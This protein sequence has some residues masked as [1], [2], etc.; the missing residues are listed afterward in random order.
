MPG[1]LDARLGEPRPGLAG[2][3]AEPAGERA[4]AHG[5]VLGQVGELERLVEAGQRPR[6]RRAGG[7]V[8]RRRAPAA[9]CTAPARR[10][11]AAAR[12]VRRATPLATAVPWSRRTRCRHRSMPAALPAEVSTSPSSMK[13]TSASTVTSGR[14]AGSARRGPSAWWRGGRRAVRRRRARRRRCRWTRAGCRTA[15]AGE[16]GEVGRCSTPSLDRDR[17]VDAGDDDGVGGGAGSLGSG[18]ERPGSRAACATGPAVDGARC[19]PR[20]A[21]APGRAARPAGS[22]PRRRSVREPSSKPRRSRARTTTRCGAGPRYGEVMA[23]FFTHAVLRATR[24]TAGDRISRCC[25]D[26]DASLTTA[27]PAIARRRRGSTAPGWSPPSP[28]WRS[29]A[30]PPSG[31]CRACS[32]TR[33]TRSS[34]GRAARSAPRS[35]ST[36]CC[37]GYR[38]VRRGADGP[39]RHP[40]GGRRAPCCSSRRRGLTSS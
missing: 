2:L 11:A 26:D 12:R 38:A 14:A 4:H 31:P 27:D 22:A 25:D 7:R 10:R 5:G 33:C 3:L 9:R 20:T 16:R 37:T 21:G 35:R 39:L 24:P 36:S 18:R 17:S 13:S 1:P 30:P 32:S 19:A 6:A 8:G 29:S 15:V 40:A 34:A 28:S 23:R